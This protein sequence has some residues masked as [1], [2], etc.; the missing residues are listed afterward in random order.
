MLLGCKTNLEFDFIFT[1]CRCRTHFVSVSACVYDGVLLKFSSP[2]TSPHG[3]KP[4]P[5][6]PNSLPGIAPCPHSERAKKC[7]GKLTSENMCHVLLTHSHCTASPARWRVTQ[8][9]EQQE[10]KVAK[11]NKRGLCMHRDAHRSKKTGAHTARIKCA[12]VIIPQTHYRVTVNRA[13]QTNKPSQVCIEP[14]LLYT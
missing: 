14:L 9:G 10:A 3:T 13:N 6:P 2:P 11:S 5:P 8:T 7:V 4:H 1:K 12:Q